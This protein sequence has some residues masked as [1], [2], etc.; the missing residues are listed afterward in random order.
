[1]GAAPAALLEAWG[2]QAVRLSAP[3]DGA[4]RDAL[5]D[6]G[7]GAVGSGAVDVVA[8]VTRDDIVAL[9][10]ALLAEHVR[11]G[12]RLAV[13]IFD[14]TTAEEITRSV[15][16]CS[17]I[18]LTDA[19]V[20][21]LLAACLDPRHRSVVTRG[22]I[23]LGV[24]EDGEPAPLPVPAPRRRSALAVAPYRGLDTSARA[25]VV[26]ALGL[27]VSTAAEAA[28][29]VLVLHEHVEDAL[30]HAARILTTV[31]S[32]P[33]A[34]HGPAWYKVVSTV[35][36]LVT[37]AW[38]GLFTAG[39]VDR[40]TGSKLTALVGRRALPR[41][42]HVVVVGVGQV[43]LRLCG[44]LRELGVPVVGVERD[45]TARWLPVAQHD[46][47][48]VVVGRGGDRFLLQRVGI[49][50]AHALA[51]VTS[52]TAENVAVAVAARAV[53]PEGRIV[54]RAGGLDDVVD[55][56]RS[57]FRIGAVCDVK[58]VIG[59]QLACHVVGVAPET[60]FTTPSGT[61]HAVV[62]GAVV[63]LDG[64]RAASSPDDVDN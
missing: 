23:L 56:S 47:I 50:S 4:V 12:V 42:G 21:N 33:A 34:E 38:V 45:A 63:D 35:L 51:A 40:V 48:P 15:P 1:M 64:W 60:V 3:D 26:S 59:A 20:D 30:W 46:R 16:N 61:L 37:L 18:P 7:D 29:G 39:L 57:L 49:T 28:L 13:T 19:I 8:V 43:G 44:R 9:R 41:R 31:G 25:L 22:E 24:G 36:M 11:P 55:E 17:A 14:R 58:A 32:S 10:Y 2:N 54:L 53:A 6:A 5:D 27:L 62:D 52:D